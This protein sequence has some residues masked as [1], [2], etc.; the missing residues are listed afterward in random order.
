[1][2]KINFILI[3]L[4]LLLFSFSIYAQE[5]PIVTAIEIKGLKRIE[6]AAVKNKISIKLGEVISQEKISED[7]KSI[8]RMAYFEDVKADITPFEGGVKVI[9]TVK[10]KPTITKVSF[11][12]NKK[13][14]DEKLKEVVTITAGSIADVTLIND[15][16]LRLKAFYESEGYYFAKIVPLLKKKTEEEVELTYII[17]ENNKVKIKEIKFEGNKNISS[18]KIKKVMATSE[19][20]FYSFITGSGFYKK[21]E[22]LQDLEKIKDL[23]YDNG[24]LKVSVG[25]PKLD[26]S[27]DKTWMTITIPISEG[28]QFKVSS[29][30]I[31]GTKDKK[32]EESI[33]AMV[34]LKAGDIF[35]KAKMRKDIEAIT[36]YYSDRGYALASVAPDVVPN[37]EKLTAEVIYNIKQGDKFTIGRVNIAGNTKTIDKVIRREVRV[38]EGD[39]YSASKINKSKKRLEDL[40]Y[41]E[42]VDINQKP[43]P[44]KKTVDLDVSVKEKATGF[45]TVGGGYSSIDNLIGMVDVTQTNLFGRGYSLT[46]RGELGGKSS[47]YTIAF[48]DPWFLDKPLL[49]GFNLYRQKREYVNYTKDGTGLSITFGKRYGEDWSASITYEIEKSKVD[50]VSDD[51]DAIIKDMKGDLITSAINFQIVNDTRDSYIDPSTGRRHSL[52]I[53]TAGLGGDTGFW[54]SMLDLGWYIPIF[55]ESTLHLRG[56][57][58]W[59][60]TLFGKKYPLYERYY[61]G[62]LDT[63]RGL[64]YGEAGPK[65]SKNEPIGA[66]KVIIGNIEYLFP[67]VTEMKLKGIIFFDIGKGYNEGEKFGSNI[68]YSSGFGFR[69]FSPMGPIKIDYGINL[70]RKEGESKSKIEFGFGSFF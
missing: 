60:D 30:Q 58:G 53:T 20:K 5:L 19:R 29:L 44:D 40:Q 50:N 17:E 21:I 37:E 52:S 4:V 67:I 32:E 57:I 24:Y 6:E 46:L 63:I 10:E 33:K 3:P 27:A 51:A 62:G 16:S 22:M 69:W 41:F 9:Y 18:R 47:Y 45:L 2:K 8:Y 25:E 49:F 56:R 48:R 61:V 23:Y 11:E 68:K 64:G 7:I 65:D 70:N 54:K 59:S 1:M 36:S 15:N 66:K 43:D 34:K 55:E 31:M 14:D 28:P 38:D 39:D 12:G 35:S 42:T 26:F 13:Y